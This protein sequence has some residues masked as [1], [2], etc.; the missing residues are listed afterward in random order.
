MVSV[1]LWPSALS[2]GLMSISSKL[3]FFGTQAPTNIV[4]LGTH[5]HLIEKLSSFLCNLAY[6][7]IT[8]IRP[9][10][11]TFLLIETHFL[12]SIKPSVLKNLQRHFRCGDCLK[13]FG[14]AIDISYG[15]C[16]TKHIRCR[17]HIVLPYNTASVASF[18]YRISMIH[19]PS[20]L[21]F[22]SLPRQPLQTYK[23]DK[24][25]TSEIRSAAY[26]SAL[27]NSKS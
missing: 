19:Q 6:C 9:L 5:R 20:L 12:G 2:I 1:I 24:T 18:W 17:I 3:T 25:G 23:R 7:K 21:L 10:L 4:G 11:A 27:L 13:Y 14:T 22:T 15:I 26:L 8:S 16:N